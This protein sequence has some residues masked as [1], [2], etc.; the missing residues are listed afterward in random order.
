[1]MDEM[2]G[3]VGMHGLHFILYLPL[4]IPVILQGLQMN[5][6]LRMIPRLSSSLPKK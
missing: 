1:M 5:I 3:Q 6:S 4:V 2:K